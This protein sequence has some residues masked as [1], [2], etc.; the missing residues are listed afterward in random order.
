MSFFERLIQYDSLYLLPER[1]AL[2]VDYK[3]GPNAGKTE[4]FGPY[5]YSTLFGVRENDKGEER[6]FI[7]VR[8]KSM[9]VTPLIWKEVQ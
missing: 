4:Y 1:R 8:A 6:M 7:R 3:T 9:L 5:D 2:K